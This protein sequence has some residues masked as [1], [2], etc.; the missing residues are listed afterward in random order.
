MLESG[1]IMGFFSDISS[2]E[3]FDN[4]PGLLVSVKDGTAGSL[5]VPSALAAT[6]VIALF[7]MQ[8]KRGLKKRQAQSVQKGHGS[9]VL[10][11]AGQVRVSKILVHPI[12]SCKGISVPSSNY[13]PEGLEYDRIWSVIDA[14]TNKIITAREVSK[15]ILISPQIEKDDSSP[16][17][18]TLRVTVPNDTS[19]QTFSIPLEPTQEIL[20]TWQILPQITIWPTHPPVDGYICESV[21]ADGLSPS[22]LL[23]QYFGKSVHLV[24]KGPRPRESDPTVRYPGLKATAKYQDMYPLLILSE[25]NI[26]AI[27]S[28]LRKHV[29]TQGIGEEWATGKLV[30]ERYRPNIILKGGG[31]FAEDGWDEISI[32]ADDAPAIS[33]VSYCTRCLLPNVNPETGVRDAA[34]PY[35]VTM[36]FRT[37]LDP[38]QKLKPCVGCNA[39]PHGNGRISVGDWVY[40]KRLID[41][42][43]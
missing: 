20:E 39:V 36:K 28:E 43:S 2:H 14:A 18:G 37:G 38:K 34:V 15:M 21:F 33:L 40:V 42:E 9:A 26:P 7:W 12:K 23:S 11:P 30:I 31:A 8:R 16:F 22:D 13:T 29:G 4:V 35:K 6:A 24:Y 10:P 3:L 25:E 1:R 5:Y 19:L 41:P 17:K 32:G 27:E